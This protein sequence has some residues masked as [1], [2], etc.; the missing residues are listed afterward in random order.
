MQNGGTQDFHK[1]FYNEILYSDLTKIL[2]AFFKNRTN[3]T[4]EAIL[5][6]VQRKYPIALGNQTM[7]IS[8]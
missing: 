3:A 4:K 7:L 6:R 1:F 8:A 5:G 2:P